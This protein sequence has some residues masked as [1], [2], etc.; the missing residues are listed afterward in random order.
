MPALDAEPR[1]EDKGL[2]IVLSG[3]K[4]PSSSRM[5]RLAGLYRIGA[6][7]DN[8]RL[9]GRFALKGVEGGR[10]GLDV[11]KRSNGSS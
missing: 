2:F 6:P 8:G 3:E 5:R 10:L 11:R 7:G 1:D 4:M 9:L